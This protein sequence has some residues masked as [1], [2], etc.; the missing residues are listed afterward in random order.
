MTDST[1]GIPTEF[2]E[3]ASALGIAFDPGDLER[4][5]RYLELLYEA[6]QRMNLTAV[7]DRDEAW[8]RHILDSLSLVPVL[9]SVEP[10]FVIDI[11]SGGGLPGIPLAIVTPSAR[12][13]LLEATGKKAAFLQEVVEQLGLDNV[14]IVSSRA[15]EAAAH[16]SAHRG[17]FDLVTARAV[18]PLPVLLEL[19]IP[20]A[21]VGGIVAAIKGERAGAE[22]VA[23]EAAMMTLRCEV[24]DQQRTSTG[25]ILL[26]QKNGSTPRAYPRR[27]GEPKRRPL[28]CEDTPPRGR[29]VH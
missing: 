6:N 20:F 7:R 19:T 18:G 24:V 8:S 22:V 17:S 5:S 14:R 26:V 27:S 28:G 9:A 10:A 25:T 23:A 21:R 1:A 16:G 2:H 4:L 12:F 3:A 13:V 15:E 29:D 11:G